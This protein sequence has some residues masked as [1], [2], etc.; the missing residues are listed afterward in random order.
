MARADLGQV[1][2]TNVSEEDID[3][4]VDEEIDVPGRNCMSSHG[5]Y[6]FWNKIK[7]KFPT[8]PVSITNGGTGANNK[9]DAIENLGLKG[10]EKRVLLWENP[11]PED[12]FPNTTVSLD[13]SEYESV[14]ISADLQPPEKIVYYN[15]TAIGEKT[16]WYSMGNVIVGGN[17]YLYGRK[18][19]VNDNSIT[20]HSCNSKRPDGS[21]H[22]IANEIL[23][24]LK[25]YG[26][27]SI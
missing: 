24:P 1:V 16:I 8:F 4:I 17:P 18:V 3:T 5:L 6:Y 25:I 20:F 14:I 12:E 9:A 27:K 26:V 13:L 11:N 22:S 21:S 10:V 7:A 2:P 19:D 23:V 15:E